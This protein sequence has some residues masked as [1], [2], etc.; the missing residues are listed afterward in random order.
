MRFISLKN[1]P[2]T[3]RICSTLAFF[4]SF[5][6]IFHF[7]LWGFCWRGRKNVSCSR[8]QVP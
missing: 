2:N 7:K 6:P 8:A 5:A 1:K 4:R 3:Y